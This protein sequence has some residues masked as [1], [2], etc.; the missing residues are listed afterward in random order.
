MNTEAMPKCPQCG[1]AL[2]PNA[3]AGLCPRCVMAM[4]LK[5]ETAFSGDATAAQPPLPPEQIAPHFP[6]LEILECLGRGGMGVVYKAR[7]KSLNRFV[8][9]KLLAPERAND[10][11]FAARFEKEARA[12]AVLNHPNIVTIY[13]HGQAGGFYFLLM[14]FV[15]GVTL[16]QLLAKERVA[17]REALAIVPQ[18]CDALQFAHDQGIVHRDIKPENILLD[19]RGR[20]KVADFGLAK[21]VGNDG[22]ADLPV[23]Q[24]G[25]AAQQHRPT[26]ALT[27][28][29]RVMGTPQY[30]SPEQI[31]AP[32]EVDHRADIYA[33]GV[34][35]YQMLTGELPGKQLEAPSKKVSID[36]RLDEIVLRALE[37]KPELRYQQ[38]S[39]VK[40]LVETIATDNQKEEIRIQKPK[41]E[42]SE[43]NLH[44]FDFTIG[45]PQ[46]TERDGRACFYWPGVLLF[47][48]TIGFVAIGVNLA[49]GLAQWLLKLPLPHGNNF[50]APGE[51]WLWLAG[52]GFCVVGRLAALNVGADKVVKVTLP[53]SKSVR[54]FIIVMAS[55]A[56][57]AVLARLAGSLRSSSTNALAGDNARLVV[58]I[59]LF[60]ALGWLIIR[61]V[62]RAVNKG[63]ADVPSAESG[64][65]PGLTAETNWQPP[66]SGWGWFIGQLAGITFTSPRAFALAN[67]S[68]LGFLGFFSYFSYAPVPGAHWFKAFSG[69]F[70]VFGLIG[71]AFGVE[72]RAR[73]KKSGS[74]PP[75]SRRRDEAQAG[76]AE[77]GKPDANGQT[78]AWWR[79]LLSV[80][81]QV[82]AALPTLVFNNLI[83]P[84]FKEIASSVHVQ[85]PGPTLFV[86]YIT[87]LVFEYLLVALALTFLLSWLMHRWGGRTLLRR[88]TAGVVAIWFALFVLNAGVVII[89]MLTAAPPLIQGGP[90]IFEKV[91]KAV[92]PAAAPN[93]AFGPVVERV[94]PFDDKGNTGLLDLD[95][96]Q[97]LNPM[98]GNA[99]W[100]TPLA[101]AGLRFELT[102]QMRM[103]TL[104]WAADVRRDDWESL[105]FETAQGALERLQNFPV[106]KTQFIYADRLPE[107]FLF[108]NFANKIGLLQITGFTANPR[109]VKIR[110]K[111]VQGSSASIYPGD[112]IWE[113]NSATLDRVPPM[114][115]LRPTAFPTNW[116]PSG[117]FGQGRYVAWRQTLKEMVTTVWSQK[118]SALKIIF[119]AD[120]PADRYDFIVAGDAHW[121][122]TLQAELDRRFHLVETIE[123]RDGTDVVV[124]SSAASNASKLP[125]SAFQIRRVA[126]DLDN[127]AATETVTN[128]LDANHA[129][130]LRLLPGVLLDGQAIERAGWHADKSQTNF[131]VGLTE[132]GSR[133]FEALTAANV[134]HR[135]AIIFQGRVLFAPNI[136]A[137]ISS[138]T[139]DTPV[140]WDMKDLERTMNGLN[141]MINPVVD[142]R[143]GPEQESILPPLNNNW[144]FLNLRDNRLLTTSISDFES[145]AF[146]DWQRTSGADLAA[147]MEEKF[148]LLVGYGM[149][150]APAI[151]NGLD[152]ASPADIWYNWNLMVNEPLTRTTLLKEP[153]NG[154][155][156][157]YF[158]TRDDTW[159]ILQI[160]GFTD[161]PRGVK[162]RYKLVQN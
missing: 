112:W 90:A 159:G 51:L 117:M 60:A 47:C 133:Q 155:D 82:L 105:T 44:F 50:Y 98:P 132:E 137:A 27:D 85:L 115:L 119:P 81:A 84:K 17:A 136:Q 116:V 156:T 144:T 48:S 46:R 148:P 54:I 56:W 70:G 22:R 5:T 19:R 37:Q 138:R 134:K 162:L 36:V 1:A 101:T 6:Q 39:E 130:T 104:G 3:L 75:G 73:R 100:Q 23:S 59:A 11:Q 161:N 42:P 74:I 127:S 62:W 97:I 114:F 106:N 152:N 157:Y 86:L 9:L 95:S 7:Q 88:W 64:V 146:H 18:I 61:R 109:G 153:N 80:L 122:D 89:P 66:T 79:V 57:A 30:M 12:L 151:A 14:E 21:I 16:R 113:P 72:F 78:G 140:N 99:G 111:L 32:G 71:V 147:A 108:K 150:T 123:N 120:L 24:G 31:H 40:T 107:T 126:D 28:A 110:Y 15:D 77:S 102:N 94:L 2:P 141:Q 4:N 13:D 118:N 29:S 35:F 139:F 87:S 121:Y 52:M 10:P 103:T 34:V 38:V 67:L 158:R 142:L 63:S 25:E 124:V 93:L 26:S 69:A 129:E 160:T 154:Q 58:W 76:K 49:F 45:M 145:R 135:I 55:I 92:T 68:A 125:T 43:S 65:A 149:A 91:P 41:S 33:L 143:F 131:V 96:G 128:F 83:V 8:A 53:K 20:V